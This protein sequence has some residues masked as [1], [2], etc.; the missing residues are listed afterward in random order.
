[1]CYNAVQLARKIFKDAKRLGASP[2]ELEEI[3][4]KIEIAE[5]NEKA[6]VVG[7]EHPKLHLFHL[8][9][10][11]QLDLAVYHWGLIPH[12]TKTVEDAKSIWNRTV[13][14][15]GETIFEKPSFK[16]AAN[17]HRCIV[18]LDGFFEHF[19]KNKKTYP[20]YIHPKGENRLFVAGISDEWINPEKQKRVHTVTIVTSKANKMMAEIHNNPKKDEPR[21]PLILNDEEAFQWLHEKDTSKI[22]ALVKPN[23]SITLES[24]TVNKLSGYD[25][26]TKTETVISPK[27]YPDLEDPLTLF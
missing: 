18:P 14:A 4:K 26:T 16:Q 25:K 11:K 20:H 3:K 17:Q 24:Y 19:H 1:M 5:E 21:M 2:E 13:N 6:L 10:N 27:H 15:R 23:T 22:Q 9:E 12:W 7:M 8:N